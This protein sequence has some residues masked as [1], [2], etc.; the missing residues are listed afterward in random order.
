[1]DFS[2]LNSHS[3]EIRSH[4][5]K[6]PHVGDPKQENSI[7]LIGTTWTTNFFETNISVGKFFDSY[8]YLSTSPTCINMRAIFFFHSIQDSKPLE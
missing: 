1:M 5:S 8:T 2:Q 6:A 4:L 7:S 3:P